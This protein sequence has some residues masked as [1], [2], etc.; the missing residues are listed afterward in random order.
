M[1]IFVAWICSG[2]LAVFLLVQFLPVFGIIWTLCRWR[3]ELISD[4]ECPQAA[5]VLVLRGRDP[6][7]SDC[8]ERLLDLDYPHYDVKI[9][10]DHPE[11]PAW[12]AVQEVLDR[13]PESNVQVETLQVPLKTCTLNCSSLVQA[14]TGLDNSHKVIGFC[15][16]DTNPHASWLRELVTPLVKDNVDIVT[17]Q[18]WFMP[19][20]ATMGSLVR[21][22][23]NAATFVATAKSSIWGGSFALTRECLEGAELV[24]CWRTCMGSD[25]MIYPQIRKHGFHLGFVPSVMMINRETCDL[26]G[27]YRWVQRQLLVGRLYLVTFPVVLFHGITSTI[28]LLSASVLLLYSLVVGS[29]VAALVIACALSLYFLVNV[30]VLGMMEVAVRRIISARDESVGWIDLR[31]LI[32]GLVAVPLSQIVYVSAL[33]NAM[34]LRRFDWRGASYVVDGPWQITLIEYKPFQ[35]QGQPVDGLTSL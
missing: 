25:A 28:L 11:D 30:I 9:V 29:H 19:A 31:T 33:I 12:Q 14:V 17:G 5:V 24:D 32:Q 10:I 4:D 20:K 1:I 35:P 7:L 21:Y 22:V 27:F 6:F 8:I 34:S 18:R 26:P 13:R 15:D 2:L 3:R 16:A 23:W